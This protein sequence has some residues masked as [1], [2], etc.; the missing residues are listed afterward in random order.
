MF[1]STIAAVS[2]PRGKGGVALIR[3]SGSESLSIAE[4][5]FAPA[6]H[7]KVSDFAPRFQIYGN[8]LSADGKTVLDDG[9]CTCFRAPASFTGEDVVELCCHGGEV[10]AALVLE[11]ALQAGAV[12]AGPGEFSRRALL[13]GKLTLT[14]AEGIADLLD[15]KTEA[16]AHLSSAAA[17]GKLSEKI[18]SLSQR[19][20]GAAASLWAYL[21]Y[22][23]E[24][25]QAFTDEELIA[26]LEAIQA[27]CEKLLRTFQTGKAVNSG[28]RTLII[29]KPNVG[30]ST[31]FNAFLGENRAIVTEIPG[32]TRDMIEVS[33]KAGHVLLNL[34][35]TAGIRRKTEDKIE[36]IGIEKVLSELDSAELVLAL[37][38]SSRPLDEDDRLILDRLQDRIGTLP[39]LPI[40]TK[41]DLPR[42]IDPEPI[43]ALGSPIAICAKEKSDWRELCN[44]IEA[45]FISDEAALHEGAVLTNIRQKT[46]F[47]KVSDLLAEAVR[48]I[49]AGNKDIASLGLES[50]VAELRETDGKGAGEMILNEVFSRFCIGK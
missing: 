10:V 28:V 22:P 20:L 30:K 13:N 19:L 42:Q 46:H 6:A 37:F 36:K 15:A 23:E 50:A 9:L 12:M 47:I 4:K 41:A 16:A 33:A 7:K 27:E 35:D 14:A 31:F 39:I 2:T 32:T 43:K 21:D 29:G 18:D 45:L 38:D 8:I 40:L 25:L 3:I 26:E 34:T 17:R 24:D 1:L 49:S 44:R 48:Q 5:I 11:A